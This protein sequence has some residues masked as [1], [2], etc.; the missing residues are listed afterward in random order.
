MNNYKLLIQYDGTN[1]S[2][3]QIQLNA[4]SVQQEITNA[5]KTLT[6]E[7]VNLIGSGRTD[8]GVHAFGQVANFRTELELESYRFLYSLNSMLPRDISI[9]SMDNVDKDFHSRFDAKK[10]SYLYFFINYKSPFYFK[11]SCFHNKKLNCK[12]L[13]ELSKA[14]IGKNDFTSFA[15]KKKETENTVCTIYNAYWKES[16]GIVIFYI[17]ADRFLHGMVRTITGTILKLHEEKK[18]AVALQEII[19]SKN[20]CEAGMSL[21]PNGLFLYKVKY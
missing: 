18:S 14:L 11:Y 15:K 3:W 7:N 13:N 12:S 21:P 17:Q 16:K 1:Y 19:N 20:R 5:I 8:A 6:T 2:G 4:N 10:R 9:L